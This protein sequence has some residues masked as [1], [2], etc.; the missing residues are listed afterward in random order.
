MMSYSKEDIIQYR[1]N[2]AKESLE[3]AKLLALSNYWNTTVNRLYYV[4]YYAATAY[5]IKIEKTTSSHSGTKTLFNQELIKTKLLDLEFGILYNNLF[6]MRHEGDYADFQNSL[7][8][9]LNP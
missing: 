7:K 3:E 1:I 2:R 8:K 6:N 5:F 4:I 9:K